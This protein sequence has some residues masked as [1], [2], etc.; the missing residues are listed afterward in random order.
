MNLNCIKLVCYTDASHANLPDG[1]SQGGLYIEV[2][3][4]NKKAPLHW[5]SK[6]IKRIVK[7]SMAAET[8]ALVEGIET[9]VLLRSLLNEILFKNKKSIA[10]EAITDSR[11]VFESAHSTNQILDKGQR[12]NMSI[13]RESI[14]EKEIDLK[15]VPTKQ[16]LANV[17]PKVGVSLLKF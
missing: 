8:L 6:R 1:G 12:I 14:A 3:D 7:S 15:W 2:V 17:L 13:L 5:Q 9:A 4:G 10:I 16:Q 11:A